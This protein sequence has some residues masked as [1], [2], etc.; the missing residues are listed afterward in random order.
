M[1]KRQLRR[2]R[3]R[4]CPFVG[5][6]LQNMF[7][8]NQ[9]LRTRYYNQ[10]TIELPLYITLYLTNNNRDWKVCPLVSCSSPSRSNRA[11]T[12][13]LTAPQPA[14]G[15]RGRGGSRD[16]A[17][18]H[19]RVGGVEGLPGDR[20]PFGVPADDVDRLPLRPASALSSRR[21]HP[22]LASSPMRRPSSPTPSR[23]AVK[24]FSLPQPTS[25]A[26]SPGDRLRRSSARRRNVCSR[27][28]N[29][30]SYSA[31]SARGWRLYQS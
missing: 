12:R 1:E 11:R 21:R 31:E 17:E 26:R 27:P 8:H 16:G 23:R 25:S 3:T 29:A 20:E 5:S 24:L 15:C 19:R 30:R 6:V 9:K 4:Q 7:K 28:R 13:A 22:R 14:D 10:W 2:Y 18:R